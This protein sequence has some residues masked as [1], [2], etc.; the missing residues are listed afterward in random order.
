VVELVV[1]YERGDVMAS[2]H[3]EGEVVSTSHE[4][5]GIRVRARLADASR[6]RLTEFIVTPS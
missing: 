5:V 1:P 6:G 2:I 4:D 3:R